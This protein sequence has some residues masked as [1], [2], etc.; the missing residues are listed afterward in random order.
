MW[1]EE[2]SALIA[3]YL[4]QMPQE[5]KVELKAM[6]NMSATYPDVDSEK[7]AFIKAFQDNLY[8]DDCVGPMSQQFRSRREFKQRPDGIWEGI[9]KDGDQA[10]CLAEKRCTYRPWENKDETQCL[11]TVS[12]SDSFC[13]QCFGVDCNDFT[14]MPKCNFYG[15]NSQSDCQQANGTWSDTPKHGASRCTLAGATSHSACMVGTA[16][17]STGRNDCGQNEC[18][19]NI[20]QTACNALGGGYFFDGKSQVCK[21]SANSKATCEAGGSGFTWSFGRFFNDGQ[22]H[23]KELCDVGRCDSTSIPWGSKVTP[24]NQFFKLT[25]YLGNMYG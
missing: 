17:A 12:E 6:W 7:A 20:T 5:V 23:T 19:K 1:G 13:G 24:V 3:C 21:R 8:I 25:S 14:N 9:K 4:D 15:I 11:S 2:S 22:Y 18:F 10:G 16:C